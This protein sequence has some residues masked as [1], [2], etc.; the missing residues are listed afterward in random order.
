[1][2]QRASFNLVVPVLS[3]AHAPSPE[4]LSD[5]GQLN[6]VATYEHGLF[7][8][9]GHEPDGVIWPDWIKPILSWFSKNYPDETWLRFD[10]E[11]DVIESLP[12][13]EWSDEAVMTPSDQQHIAQARE[14]YE[15]DEIEIDEE[16]KIAYAVNAV[17]VNA[18]LRVLK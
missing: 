2:S 16:P 17:W 6:M 1:M 4:A 15:S 11:G 14:L 7:L 18:W 13:H 10:G 12:R 9:V 3:T 8:F 5:L